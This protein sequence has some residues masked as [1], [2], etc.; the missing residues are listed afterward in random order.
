MELLML[1]PI[2]DREAALMSQTG[3]SS[4]RDGT[5]REA[6]DLFPGFEERWIDAPAGR[7]FAR[8]G[9]PESA[10]A[11]VLLHGFPET[12]ASWHG[13]APG[14]AEAH[15]VV[16]L[17]LKGYGRSSAPAGDP[18]HHAYSKRAMG[19]DVVSVLAALGHATFSVVGHDRGALI[20]YRIALDR[21]D[22]IE[23]L[24]V[25][26]NLPTFVI[27][28][29]MEANA[30]VTPHWRTIARPPFEPE[31]MLDQAYMENML[32]IHTADGTLDCFDEPVL[33]DFRRSWRDPAR[34][35]AF[36]EDYRAGAGLDPD[37][38]RRDVAEDRTI[39]CPTLILWG[40]AFLG[41]MPESPLS[42][43]RRTFAPNAV[44]V[45]VPGGHFNGEESPV[46][47]LAA[48][49]AFFGR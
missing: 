47:T 36:C 37:A 21:P 23:R 45:E 12:H 31:R 5:D 11:L 18:E 27:W 35:H 1:V 6:A 43:W 13:I 9:G 14:L 2:G 48:L 33:E 44:G 15:R 29:M 7:F 8:V 16:C 26:D 40:A 38:D 41:K 49:R 34:V 39:D 19:D 24:A 17:D 22:R 30:S 10:P 25:L 32:R 4:A 3:V 42:I 46:E 20:G 28:E